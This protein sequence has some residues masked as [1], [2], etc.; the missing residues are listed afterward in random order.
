[1]M[2]VINKRIRFF[3]IC[4]TVSINIKNVIISIFVFII[5]RSD[6]KLLLRRFS[7]RAACMN[8]INMNDKF[9]EM[10]LHSLNEKKRISFLNIFVE[11]V[12]NKDEKT[13]FTM[14]HLNV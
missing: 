8:F 3:D 13:I 4:K 6:Y 10:I 5:K 9:F 7:Q 11:Y 14:K 12:N 2:N 1:M